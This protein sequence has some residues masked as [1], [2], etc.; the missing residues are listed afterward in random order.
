MTALSVNGSVTRETRA[1]YR[2]RALVVTLTGHELIFREKGRRRIV[3]VPI[4][5]AYDLGFKI[6]AREARLEKLAKKKGRA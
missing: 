5:A 4:L 3:A 6:L 1:T 2:G